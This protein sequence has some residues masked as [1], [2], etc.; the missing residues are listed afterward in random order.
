MRSAILVAALWAAACSS[1]APSPTVATEAETT[2]DFVVTTSAYAGR[3]SVVTWTAIRAMDWPEHQ[4]TFSGYNKA[5][6]DTLWSLYDTGGVELYCRTRFSGSQAATG[7]I[8]GEKLSIE[9]AVPADRIAQGLGYADRDCKEKLPGRAAKPSCTFAIS[10]MHN[11]WPAYGRVNSS[12]NKHRLSQLPGEGTTSP[13]LRGICRDFERATDQET[14]I[15]PTARAQGDLAR[16][17]IY[18]SMVY[19]LPLDTAVDDPDLLLRWHTSDPPDAEERRREREIRTLQG[20][21]NPLV[22]PADE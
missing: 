12:R 10:D 2:G 17:L 8:R 13:G 5:T 11:L 4:T 6:R 3:A 15:E 16:S 18:M 20:T 7:K 1:N 22:L 14:L 19:D 9:H 21:W